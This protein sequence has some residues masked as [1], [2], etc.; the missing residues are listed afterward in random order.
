[1]GVNFE[2]QYQ[3]LLKKKKGRMKEKSDIY[4]LIIFVVW[5][6]LEYI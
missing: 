2:E 3:Q 6:F 4:Q 1:M 5:T